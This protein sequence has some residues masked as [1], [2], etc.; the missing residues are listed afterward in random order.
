MANN[1][2]GVRQS[3]VLPTFAFVCRPQKAQ[4][5]NDRHIESLDSKCLSISSA[6]T[7]AAE[8]AGCDFGRSSGWR[9][10]SVRH[11][12]NYGRSATGDSEAASPTCHASTRSTSRKKS[13]TS[14][15]HLMQATHVYEVRP[16]KD[17]RSVDLILKC[18]HSVGCGT[19]EPDH[20][21]E[22]AKFRSRSHHAVIRVYDES[23][24]VIETHEHGGDRNR[25]ANTLLQS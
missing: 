20:A 18:C 12:F 25:D 5:M 1:K 17:H 2:D 14:P 4:F 23:G 24:N 10:Q 3:R 22:Y 6:L 7:R 21:I 19:G 15:N 16:R 9:M 8:T 11:Q 13:P